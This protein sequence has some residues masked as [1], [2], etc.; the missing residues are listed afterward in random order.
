MEF[1]MTHSEVMREK[2]QDEALGIRSAAWDGAAYCEV[3]SFPD[4]NE[5]GK[6]DNVCAYDYSIPFLCSVF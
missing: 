2:H 5:S 3:F 4:P 6:M 1:T